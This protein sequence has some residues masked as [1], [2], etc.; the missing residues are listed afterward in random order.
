M[1]DRRMSGVWLFSSVGSVLMSSQHCDGG[2]WG[3]ISGVVGGFIQTRAIETP[4]LHPHPP[5]TK[6]KKRT[7]C[8]PLRSSSGAC[9][10]SPAA[11]AAA[12]APSGCC[13]SAALASSHLL[14]SIDG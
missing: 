14:W 8:H 9:S 10:P 12:A 1:D 4:A 13:P 5:P 2:G 11:G 6:P 3:S 7:S